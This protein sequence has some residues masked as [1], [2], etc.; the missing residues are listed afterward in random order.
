MDVIEEK[1][2]YDLYTTLL[3]G[4]IICEKYIVRMKCEVPHP[5]HVGMPSNISVSRN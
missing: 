5:I 4:P 1:T 3:P 2:K